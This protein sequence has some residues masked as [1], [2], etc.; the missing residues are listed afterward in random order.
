MRTFAANWLPMLFNA[1]MG[2]VPH[3]A[4]HPAAAIAAYAAVAP[5]E[6]LQSMF[7]TVLTKLIEVGG[8]VCE[9]VLGCGWLF[10]CVW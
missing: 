8:C 10:W 3:A 5:S 2:A 4:A 6:L 1:Y 9:G 7:K